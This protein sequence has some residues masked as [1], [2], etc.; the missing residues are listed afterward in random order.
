MKAT[1]NNKQHNKDN[2][3]IIQITLF[4]VEGKYKALSTLVKVESLEWFKENEQEV[5][6]KGYQQICDKMGL[7]G[8]ELVKLGYKRVKVRNYS[9]WKEIKGRK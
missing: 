5:K 2:N 1:T 6:I 3:I 4:D 8:K 9:L 7:T